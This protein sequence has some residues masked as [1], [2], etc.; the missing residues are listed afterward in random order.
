MD[1]ATQL[2]TAAYDP[3]KREFLFFTPKVHQLEENCFAKLYF[4]EKNL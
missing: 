1:G 3:K 2:M 4:N